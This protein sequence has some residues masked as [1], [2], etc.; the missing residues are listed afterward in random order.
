[1]GRELD[2]SGV[3]RPI[4]ATSLKSEFN[5][6]GFDVKSTVSVV[7]DTVA[8]TLLRMTKMQLCK[9]SKRQV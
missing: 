3:L 2:A 4:D 8:T 5:G 6:R 9:I 7:F 1:M